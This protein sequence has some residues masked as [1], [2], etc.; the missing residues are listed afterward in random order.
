MIDFLKK[1]IE[2]RK[3]KITLFLFDDKNPHQQENYIIHPDKLFLFLAILQVFVLIIIFLIFYVT[4]IGTYLFNKENRAIR[5]SVIEVRE[6]IVALQDSL[7]ARDRQL[8]EIQRVLRSDV[9]TTFQIHPTEEWKRIYGDDNQY[10]QV[11]SYPLSLQKSSPVQILEGRKLIQSNLFGEDFM[12]PSEPPVRGTVT[13]SY[14]PGN[15]HYG[16]DIAATIGAD[17][18]AVADGVIIFSGW[19]INYGYVMHIMH[20]NGMITIYKHF[21]EIFF[22]TGDLVKKRDIIGKV[23]KT[24]LLATGPH[25]HFEIWK[26]GTPLDPAL[27]IF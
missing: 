27:Y 12:F 16:I 22:Q 5:S 11:S 23:G 1:L 24:G 25:L 26:N 15:G 10:S 13:Q 6:R 7:E 18:H 2:R 20:G 17:V 21:S 19:S 14:N 3:E 8:Y 9:D 4:P